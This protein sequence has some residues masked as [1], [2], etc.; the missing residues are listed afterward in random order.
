MNGW[1]LNNETE[2]GKGSNGDSASFSGVK[3][4]SWMWPLAGRTK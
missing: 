4:L 2:G 3:M 1:V